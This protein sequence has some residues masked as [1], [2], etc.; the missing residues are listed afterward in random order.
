MIDSI[1]I[2]NFKSVQD[3]TL[4]LGRFNVLIG[5][6]GSGKS[7]IL[8]AIAFGA[9]ARSGNLNYT[10]LSPRIRVSSPNHRLMKSAFK[11]N[12]LSMPISI[13]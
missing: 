3:L 10:F 2:K 8:E 7:N 6:N 4:D 1:T 13:L 9:A 12:N 5:A 11:E